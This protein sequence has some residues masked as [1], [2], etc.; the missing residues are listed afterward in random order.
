MP[1]FTLAFIDPSFYYP[2]TNLS[3]AYLILTGT[4]DPVTVSTC[5]QPSTD[6]PETITGQVTINNYTFTRA[7]FTD[8]AAGN[9]YDQ[10]SYRTV[11]DKKCFELIVLIHS[12]NIGNY[13]PGTVVEFD[14]DALLKKFEA[15]LDTFIV[16]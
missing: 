14:R 11:F 5:T 10:I 15:V 1:L 7:E 3:E 2:N 4:R 8:V 12:T 16:K 13:T 9:L 6:Q